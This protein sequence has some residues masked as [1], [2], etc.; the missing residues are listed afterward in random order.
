MR[1]VHLNEEEDDDDDDEALLD[2]WLCVD[3]GGTEHLT[4]SVSWFKHAGQS[5]I[6][7]HD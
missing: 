5:H 1:D 3:S 2:T 7:D 6:T 4:R